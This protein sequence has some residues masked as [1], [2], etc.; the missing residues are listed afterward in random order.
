[1]SCTA[2]RW[3][4]AR[5][6]LHGW[7]EQ[8][9]LGHVTPE[10]PDALE[11]LE[12]LD[13]L[14]DDLEIQRVGEADDRGHDERGPQLGKALDEQPVD[15]QLV[16]QGREQVLEKRVP[17]AEVVEGDAEAGSS[18][19][20][21]DGAVTIRQVDLGRLGDLDLD[22]RRIDAAGRATMP[23]AVLDDRTD[24]AVSVARC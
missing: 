23:M 1:M 3:A 14:G 7:R 9:A 20:A 17:R 22:R 12:R 18:E 19:S 8:E 16:G 21:T 15:L 5:P 10:P 6:G 2:D 24:R 13:P 11:L 4:T